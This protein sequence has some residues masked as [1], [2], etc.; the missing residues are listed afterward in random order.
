MINSSVFFLLLRIIKIHAV[1]SQ[2]FSG[3]RWLTI[4]E[5]PN[6][7]GLTRTSC[8]WFETIHIHLKTPKITENYSKAVKKELAKAC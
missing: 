3:C 7:D 6:I 5:R 8:N 2:L 4:N 1:K